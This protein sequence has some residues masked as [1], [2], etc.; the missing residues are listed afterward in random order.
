MFLS[1]S[2][3]LPRPSLLP[4]L[5]LPPLSP[6]L[7][8]SLLFSLSSPS[9]SF[10]ILL[11]SKHSSHKKI[12]TSPCRLTR[13]CSALFPFSSLFLPLLFPSPP[14]HSSS[15]T[16]PSLPFSLSPLP[17]TLFP[18]FSILPTSPSLSKRNRS[19]RRPRGEISTSNDEK[20]IHCIYNARD[21]GRYRTD[22]Q[23]KRY[24][25]RK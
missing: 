6:P 25:I 10:V 21:E 14:L 9:C 11:V 24:V 20:K 5:P 15:S 19:E 17:V 3:L 18:F 22:Q 8:L 4:F 16:T 23:R 12:I 7:S 1:L 13:S 2:S